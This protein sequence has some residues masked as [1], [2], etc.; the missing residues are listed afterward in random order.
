MSTKKSSTTDLQ[1]PDL[2]SQDAVEILMTMMQAATKG[3][4]VNKALVVHNDVPPVITIPSTMSKLEAAKELKRQHEE[5]ETLIDVDRRFDDYKWQD[6][7]VATKLTAEKFFGWINAQKSFMNPPTE[8]EV[9]VDYVNGIPVKTTCFYGVFKVNALEEA[10]CSIMPRGGIVHLSF[11]VKKKYKE[12][13]QEWYQ[14]ID[15]HLRSN[16][17]Y[18]G[19]SVTV[20]SQ[21]TMFDEDVA[22]EII[23]T[24]ANPKI[25]LNE[26]ERTVLEHYC[27]L[28][29]DEKGKRTYLFTGGYGNGKTEAAMILGDKAKEKG[30]C[31]FYCKDSNAFNYLLALAAKN[32][33]PCLIFM[34]DIDE[35][36]S[37]DERNHEINELLNV[38]DGAETK[39]K[40]IKVLFTTN[41][42][43]AINPALRRPG[44]LD[45]IV[46]FENPTKESVAKIFKIYLGEIK[47]AENVDWYDVAIKAP[48]CSGAF[49]AEIC[50]RAQRLAQLKGYLSSEMLLAAIGTIQDHLALTN[51]DVVGRGN[52]LEEAVMLIG[53]VIFSGKGDDDGKTIKAVQEVKSAAVNAV[54]GAEDRLT[55]KV[56]GGFKST[57]VQINEVK[58]DASEAKI[59]TREILKTIGA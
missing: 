35:I 8:I 16:S 44:R 20:T 24:K 37:G 6:V 48:D 31:F 45:L 3:N 14:L 54:S 7:L 28:D 59:N 19:K 55:K 36:G 50:K 51:T 39:N 25:I 52:K 46:R 9:I 41:H 30:M 40:D 18:R 42:H 33:S 34:E 1:I 58:E 23:E 43:D 56:A 27:M 22:F 4:Q 17:I 13:I 32:Y 12:R 15:E 21:N 49:I 5:E 53:E 38:L 10:E 26:K 2:H 57:S 47:G 29:L 11:N